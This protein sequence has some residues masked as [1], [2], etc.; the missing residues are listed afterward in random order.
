MISYLGP[1][2]EK[3]TIFEKN[4]LQWS[5]L[6]LTFFI[7][8]FITHLI[9]RKKYNCTKD[10]F[11]R[12]NNKKE[13]LP[14]SLIGSAIISSTLLG[15]CIAAPWIRDFIK[16]FCCRSFS[17]EVFWNSS[18][19]PINFSVSL[20]FCQYQRDSTGLAR[21]PQIDVQKSHWVTRRVLLQ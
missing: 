5:I 9:E 17:H 15:L 6:T 11:W 10:T 13:K 4:L 16:I 1:V 12:N 21:K 3:A 20:K 8:Y 14:M 18:F 7:S 19:H 2:K